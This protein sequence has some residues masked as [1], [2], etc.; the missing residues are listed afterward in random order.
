MCDGR[1]IVA[2]KPRSRYAST[3]RSSQA[4]LSRLY[5]QK[6]LRSGVDSRIGRRD[7]GVWYAEAELMNTYCPVR[8][9][10]SS[11][12][13]RACSGVKATQSTTAS[14]VRSPRAVR[15]ESGSRMSPTTCSTSSGTSR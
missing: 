5:C 6:G 7:T 2:G 1:T 12:S 14:N 15:T 11:T 3:S 10:K 8:P 9:S 4:I 13:V